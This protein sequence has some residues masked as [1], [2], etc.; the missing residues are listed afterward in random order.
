[1]TGPSGSGKSTLAMLLSGLRSPDSGHIRIDG[2]DIVDYANDSLR[3]ALGY[4]PQAPHFFG[5]TIRDNIT[6]FRDYPDGAVR[7]A[8]AAA[9]LTDDVARLPT[10]LETLLV[11]GG[12]SLSGG[13][14]QRLGL[15]R[16]L[17]GSPR[18]LI[19][20]E[21]TS[22]LDRAAE[23][24]VLDRVLDLGLTAIVI[25]H[26]ESVTARADRVLR[27]QAGRVVEEPAPTREGA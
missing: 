13:Q 9:Y 25:T 2:V 15:A 19:L 12:R 22:A 4:V 21:A 14:L 10:G 3:S 11:E 1:V 24:E 7:Q 6:L 18:I 27:V 16:A 23:A 17:I 8:L 20:D 5:S 26:R